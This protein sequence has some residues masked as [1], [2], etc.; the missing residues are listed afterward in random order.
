MGNWYEFCLAKYLR[1]IVDI[2]Y[3]LPVNGALPLQLA[4]VVLH[5]AALVA[6]RSRPSPRLRLQHHGTAAKIHFERINIKVQV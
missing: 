3:N 6:R 2:L 4:G 5:G 1:I